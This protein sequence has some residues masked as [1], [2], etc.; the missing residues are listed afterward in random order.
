MLGHPANAVAWLANALA[1]FDRSLEAGQVVLS[2]SI[3]KASK[4][5]ANEEYEALFSTLG[6]VGCRLV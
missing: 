2:G 4:A 3:T 1:E 5:R 6:R